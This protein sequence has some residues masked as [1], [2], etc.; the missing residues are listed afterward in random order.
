MEMGLRCSYSLWLGRKAEE[1]Q[2]NKVIGVQKADYRKV[3]SSRA[4]ARELPALISPG[5]VG[6]AGTPFLIQRRAAGNGLTLTGPLPR[7]GRLRGRESGNAH[8][9]YYSCGLKNSSIGGSP[10]TP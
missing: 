10:P 1:K 7:R 8:P 2:G 5:F 9:Y 6:K 4:E 3:T